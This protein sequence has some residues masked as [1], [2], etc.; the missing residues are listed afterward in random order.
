LSVLKASTIDTKHYANKN[1][2]YKLHLPP[3]PQQQKRQQTPMRLLM[4]AA[5]WVR[6]KRGNEMGKHKKRRANNE[7]ERIE[8]T[9]FASK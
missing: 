2:N 4:I 8:R 1:Y 7:G 3:S 6:Q 9:D 5:E